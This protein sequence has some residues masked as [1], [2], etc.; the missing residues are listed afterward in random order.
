MNLMPLGGLLKGLGIASLLVGCA[1]TTPEQP[2]VASRPSTKAPYNRPYTVNGQ[3]YYPLAS[4]S[5]YRKRGVASWYGSESG[6]R[7]A[8]GTHF[9]PR[10]L[11]AAHRTLPLP[12]RV[13]VTNLENGR[14]VNVLV[15]DRGPFVANRLIDLS[16]GAAKALN[17]RNLVQV[18]VATIGEDRV[19]FQ[20]ELPSSP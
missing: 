4:A 13:R 11:T 12:T 14:S 3:W 6:N 15:N 7:T 18:E 2:P 9:N 10:S 19:A 17:I 8:M 1:T 16:Y 5:G 20:G